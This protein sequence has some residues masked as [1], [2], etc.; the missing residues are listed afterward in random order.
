MSR[1]L[2]A[3]PKLRLRS[4]SP[5]WRPAEP[6][7][8]EDW[9]RIAALVGKYEDLRLGIVDA[10]VVAACERF[11]ETKL[12]TLD[13]RHFSIIRPRHCEAFELLPG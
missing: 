6:V 7:E 10:L 11:G 1:P 12:A 2:T 13:R 8:P 3:S 4:L 5:A 9:P